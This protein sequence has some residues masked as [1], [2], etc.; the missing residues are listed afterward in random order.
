MPP[1]APQV[2]LRKAPPRDIVLAHH[3]DRTS[4]TLRILQIFHGVKATL[5]QPY[6]VISPQI[7]SRGKPV[8]LR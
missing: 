4:E 8:S 7:I 6:C 5:T 2:R 3:A 1:L